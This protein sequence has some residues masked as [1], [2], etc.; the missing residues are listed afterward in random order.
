MRGTGAKGRGLPTKQPTNP[1]TFTPPNRHHPSQS[2]IPIP[3]IPVQK[4]TNQPT[5]PTLHPPSHHQT[6]TTHHSPSFQSRPSRFKNQPND[7]TLHPPS[8]HQTTTTHHS[9]SF[10]SRPSRFKNQPNNQHTPPTFTPPNHHHPSQS[11][12][13]IPPIP[14]QKPTEQPTNPT[15][16]PRQ[17]ATTHHSPSFQSRPSPVQ[18]P[19]LQTILL[20][21]AQRRKCPKHKGGAKRSALPG[22]LWIPDCAGMT[23][24]TPE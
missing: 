3:P 21:P 19:D 24:V 5:N 17:T 10:Q 22:P 20:I 7:H 4:P 18:N 8:H 16:Q 2:I 15:P 1:P 6:A 9:P 23:R 13:P 12:I 14:V 11:I